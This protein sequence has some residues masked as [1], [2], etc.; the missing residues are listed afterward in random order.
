MIVGISNY[1]HL[2]K[3]L[4]LQFAGRDAQSIYTILISPEGGNFK[5]ENVHM[6]TGA[7]A[8]LADLRREIDAWL[9]TGAKDNDRGLIYFA[10]NRFV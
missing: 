10:G 5:A 3:D 1:A 4:R 2:G 7:K 6:L 9:P 8:T